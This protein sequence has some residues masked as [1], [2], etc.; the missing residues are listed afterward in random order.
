M[1]RRV[2]TW[3]RPSDESTWPWDDPISNE[4]IDGLWGAL[5]LSSGFLGKTIVTNTTNELAENND[6][7]TWEDWNN[8]YTNPTVVAL[9]A[10]LDSILATSDIT[11]TITEVYI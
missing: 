11:K 9:Q 1:Y 3:T 4:T 2:I 8:F 5:V 10:T 6:W 7:A